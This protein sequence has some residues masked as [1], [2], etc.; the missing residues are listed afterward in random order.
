M[1]ARIYKPARNAL[2]SGLAGTEKWILE[3]EL[4]TPR[5]LEPLMGWTSS[6]DTLNQVSLK[7]RSKDAAVAFAENRRLEY[8]VDEPHARKVLPRNYA[9]NFQYRPCE[10]EK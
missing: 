2:Q 5:R 1:K 6:G 8:G 7:F 3:Y 9:D 10:E 4:E